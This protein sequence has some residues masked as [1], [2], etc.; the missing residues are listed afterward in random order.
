MPSL[1]KKF[2]R[3]FG[4]QFDLKIRGGGPSRTSTTE[5]VWGGSPYSF[6]GMKP[7]KSFTYCSN[8]KNYKIYTF[9]S[10]KS[11]T[12]HFLFVLVLNKYE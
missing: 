5:V 10:T 8:E 12:V 6:A 3:P 7:W 11:I 2:F 1:E 9:Y 4:P